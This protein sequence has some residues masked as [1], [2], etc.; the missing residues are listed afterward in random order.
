M[1]DGSPAAHA[2]DGLA[3]GEATQLAYAL[4]H[5][6]QPALDGAAAAVREAE[7][8]LAEVQQR[9]AHAE[10]LDAQAPYASDPLIFMRQSVDEEVDALGRKTTEKKLRVSYR[11]LLDR[12]VELAGAEVARFHD[13]QASAQRE[14][15][16][17][18]EACREAERHAIAALEDAR[19]MQER[20]RAAEQSARLGM[21]LLLERLGRETP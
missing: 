9:L 13:D 6:F 5:R 19:Q 18:I 21:R 2:G 12:A 20:V 17:G 4:E 10:A 7:R 11:F 8:M 1:V 3:V 16:D 14:R 15:H